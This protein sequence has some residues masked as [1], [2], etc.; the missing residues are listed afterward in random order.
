MFKFRKLAIRAEGLNARR[1][2]DLFAE[3]YFYSAVRI[4]RRS[5]DFLVITDYPE[6]INL[7]AFESFI[8]GVSEF[9]GCIV[10]V[11]AEADGEAVKIPVGVR[12]PIGV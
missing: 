10:T 7:E 9:P 3:T 2:L 1:L 11:L 5:I 6:G 4:D 12:S 8:R